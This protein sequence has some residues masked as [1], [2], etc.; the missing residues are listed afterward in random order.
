MPSL[1]LTDDDYEK[2]ML[3]EESQVPPQPLP[4]SLNQGGGLLPT[5]PMMN[6]M[7][8]PPSGLMHGP[9]G[10]MRSPSNGQLPGL[11]NPGNQSTLSSKMA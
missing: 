2:M 6:M 5:P 4:Y 11:A 1:I 3:A 10:I 8:P 7:N 9:N